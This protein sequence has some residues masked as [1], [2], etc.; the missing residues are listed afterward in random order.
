M[1]PSK[2][3]AICPRPMR[4][5]ADVNVLLPLLTDGHPHRGPAVQW[6]EH[7]DDNNVGLSLPVHMALLRLLTNARVMGSSVLGPE[8][9]W[10]VVALLSDDPRIRIVDRLPATHAGHWH[11]CIA[12]RE[13]SPNLWT[14]AW[15]A[16]LALAAD[17]EMVTFD[18]G[19]RAF[20]NLKLHL[21]SPSDSENSP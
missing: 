5:L 3:K 19:F 13:P 1:R 12:G 20:S 18:K 11:R 7:C 16:A 10:E 14:D 4:Y 2:P 17:C 21:L 15:L 6:W 9:A 8:R